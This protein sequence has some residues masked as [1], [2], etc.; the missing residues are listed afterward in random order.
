MAIVPLAGQVRPGR[1][2]GPARQ[3]RRDGFIPG[4]IYGHGETPVAL[5]VPKREFVLAM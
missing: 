2:K 4:V 5:A 1:G 3:A